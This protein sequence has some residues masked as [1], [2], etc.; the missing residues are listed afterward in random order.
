MAPLYSLPTQLARHLSP[1]DSQLGHITLSPVG[2]R[3]PPLSFARSLFVGWRI[4]RV[5]RGA[6]VG[7]WLLRG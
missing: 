4:L 7:G 6:R 3:T 1:R 2:I 5:Q